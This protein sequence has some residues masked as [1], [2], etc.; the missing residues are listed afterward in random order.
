MP[1][2][3]R[4]RAVAI[5]GKTARI[6]KAKTA[7]KFGTVAFISENINFFFSELYKFAKK[8]LLTK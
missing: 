6:E 7:T 2:N 3:S 1:I 5:V 8:Y 4:V